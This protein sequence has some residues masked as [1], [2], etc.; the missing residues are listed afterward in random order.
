MGMCKCKKSN[1]PRP[2]GCAGNPRRNPSFSKWL[3]TFLDEKGIDTE[4]VLEV[5]GK[6]WGTNYIP[7]GVLV[8]ALKSAPKHEQEAIKT[9]LVKIDFRN[10]PVRPYL[11]HLGQAIARNPAKR[12]N[13]GTKQ[14]ADQYQ[15]AK[16]R[17]AAKQMTDA[18]LLYVI[19]DARQAAEA[20]RSHDPIAEG[21]YEDEA[22]T[23]ADELRHRRERAAGKRRNPKK[24]EESRSKALGYALQAESA[25]KVKRA[26]DQFYGLA[27]VQV[28]HS[29]MGALKIDQEEKWFYALGSRA[30]SRLVKLLQKLRDL[31]QVAS[32]EALKH[33]DP[34][35]QAFLQEVVVEMTW[36]EK[37]IKENRKIKRRNPDVEYGSEDYRIGLFQG[38]V[39]KGKAPPPPSTSKEL[40]SGY[41]AGARVA[42]AKPAAVQRALGVYSVTRDHARAGD[43][44]RDATLGTATTA[45]PRKRRNPKPSTPKWAKGLSARDQ[46]EARRAKEAAEFVRQYDRDPVQIEARAIRG[47]I[48]D[49]VSAAKHLPKCSYAKCVKGC[50]SENWHNELKQRV[51]DEMERLDREIATAKTASKRKFWTAVR[52]EFSYTT[53]NPMSAAARK[54]LA[55]EKSE[56]KTFATMMGKLPVGVTLRAGKHRVRKLS[57]GYV[58]VDGERLTEA[59]AAAKIHRGK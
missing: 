57:K 15:F 53:R 20:M 24:A 14:P 32:P 26:I 49:P 6:S 44:L 45:N 30:R 52:A 41:A 3:D 37:L 16:W 7:V 12:R 17:E 4:E 58:V 10:A 5:K 29:L 43:E 42:K 39:E 54:H 1:P 55:H 48:N 56:E 47:R 19:K 33:L 18:E 46:F 13:P 38:A 9:M 21:W 23:M 2:C 35:Q 40:R 28:D 11:A 34:R 31:R 22:F 51:K 25:D 8:Q 27:G 59:Q 50:P 36:A